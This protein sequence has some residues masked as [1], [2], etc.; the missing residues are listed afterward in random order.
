MLQRDLIEKLRV[1]L[2]KSAQ[3]RYVKFP[4]RDTHFDHLPIQQTHKYDGHW[5]FPSGGVIN[6]ICYAEELQLVRRNEFRVFGIKI[7]SK[8]FIAPNFLFDHIFEFPDI[9]KLTDQ[10]FEKIARNIF[11]Y[12]PGGKIVVPDEYTNHNGEV[13]RL[14]K[15]LYYY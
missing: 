15:Q 12:G 14:C 13:R 1:K 4:D 3:E 6:N 8:G 2:D 11:M 7:K 5:K 9:T 10:E